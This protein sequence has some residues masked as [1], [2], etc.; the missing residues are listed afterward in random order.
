MSK[1]KRSLLL[2]L[3]CLRE[4][5]L[6]TNPNCRFPGECLAGCTD[7]L[8]NRGPELATWDYLLSVGTL[9]WQSNIDFFFF[10][11]I[12]V[13]CHFHSSYMKITDTNICLHFIFNKEVT[14]N[15]NGRYWPVA[16]VPVVASGHGHRG[17]CR[18]ISAQQWAKSPSWL[19]DAGDS[20]E[21]RC[22]VTGT[23]VAESGAANANRSQVTH[24]R[25]DKT[26]A[27][28]ELS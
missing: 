5:M 19:S 23:F 10:I 14:L 20:R 8:P 7:D 27:W 18:S 26:T 15:D 17:I 13:L 21:V 4:E 1:A 9:L 16:T 12:I 11:L 22:L 28:R 3:H 6:P 25:T 2:P 24:R